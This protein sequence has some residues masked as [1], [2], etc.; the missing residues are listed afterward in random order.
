VDEYEGVAS[1]RSW[2][3][4]RTSLGGVLGAAAAL[5]ATAPSPRAALHAL[6]APGAATT[7]EQP[8]VALVA[9]LAW[10]LTVWLAATVLVTT[11]GHLPGTAG[12]LCAAIARRTAPAGVRRAVEAALGLSV[13]VGALGAS[14]AVAAGPG[15]LPAAESSGQVTALDWGATSAA[16]ADPLPASLDWRAAPEAAAPGVPAPP[17]TASG[18]A[19]VVQPGDT[20]WHLA[21]HHLT[22]HHLTEHHLTEPSGTAPTPAQVAHAWPAW[23]HANREAIGDDPHLLRPGT[24]LLSPAV[25]GSAPGDPASPHPAPS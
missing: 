22:E 16:A 19:V 5:L 6:L 13:A 24:P 12:A 7:P 17:A 11:A 21:E 2:S 8:F 10:T 20:L 15:A 1:V 4:S 14:P 25:D 9:L 3:G 18:S 23:W